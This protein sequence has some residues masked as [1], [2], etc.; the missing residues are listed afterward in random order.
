VIAINKGKIKEQR[1]KKRDSH[2]QTSPST[3][4]K[5]AKQE[6]RSQARTLA[7]KKR[8]ANKYQKKKKSQIKDQ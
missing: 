1:A 3:N 4:N 2:A 5:K 8:E 7:V 6:E